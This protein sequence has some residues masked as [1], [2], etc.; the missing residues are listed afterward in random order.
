[1]VS[2][3][4]ALMQDQS[5]TIGTA[6]VTTACATDNVDADE[7]RQSPIILISPKML[8]GNRKW[9]ILLRSNFCQENLVAIA[10]DEALC[11]KS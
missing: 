8:L 3:L 1:M 9:R 10:I 11:V 6:G 5:G 4:T 2:P 7:F